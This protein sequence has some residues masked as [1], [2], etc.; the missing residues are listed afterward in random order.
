MHSLEEIKLKEFVEVSG[1][2]FIT[3]EEIAW[4]IEQVEKVEKLK[5]V[6]KVK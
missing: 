6:L 5:R 1:E 2:N 3:K 4:L